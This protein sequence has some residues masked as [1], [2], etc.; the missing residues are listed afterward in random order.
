MGN[1]NAALIAHLRADSLWTRLELERE[2]ACP[3]ASGF[4]VKETF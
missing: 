1:W 2:C 4:P 3:D